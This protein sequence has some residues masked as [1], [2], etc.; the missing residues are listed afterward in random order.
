MQLI[1]DP[2]LLI[3]KIN[4]Y[5]KKNKEN[6]SKNSN[7]YLT[8]FDESNGYLKLLNLQKKKLDLFHYYSI[9][10]KN[11]FA[12]SRIANFKF[13][14]NN[15]DNNFNKVIITWGRNKNFSSDGFFFD[16]YFNENSKK[17]KNI[18]WI[19]ISLD[20]QIPKKISKNIALFI[21]NKKG[22][23][24]VTKLFSNF[25]KKIFYKL[26]N[27]NLDNFSYTE[28]LAVL[29]WSNLKQ[30]VNFSKIKKIIT[31][32]EA[33]PFQNYLF[34]QIHKYFKKVKTIG[35]I[36]ATQAF[37]VH[38][39]KRD[40]SPKQL[41][42][43]GKD[44]RYHL[45]KFLGWKKNEVKLI[46]SIKVRKKDKKKYQNI[47]F[48][49][50]L[51]HNINFYVNS[52]EVLFNK[53]HSK[54]SNKLTVKI[55]PLRLNKKKHQDLKS[56]IEKL[57]KNRKLNKDL[58]YCDPIILGTSSVVLEALENDLKPFH[59]TENYILDSYS[60][61]FWPSIHRKVLIKDEI[62]QY[63]LIKK[64]NCINMKSKKIN[65]F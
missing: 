30:I 10:L 25:V 41:Y 31:P 11:F 27:K 60:K 58:S 63:S 17:H 65:I 8:T 48:L 22:L 24:S 1:C 56:Q 29:I 46:P 19:V 16:Q 43:H 14:F 57:I 37:P 55:H 39:F 12:A 40:G 21:N 3:K 36:H 13:I 44:Q 62:F 61:S 38:L 34:Y 59:I 51:I 26:K 42:A 9:S 7:F 15:I 49:P 47:I 33:Q 5:F 50:F 35:Y 53:E 18:L 32:Y 20:N 2:V 4:K 23:I 54:F 45:L 28:E 52:L 6:N 64:N